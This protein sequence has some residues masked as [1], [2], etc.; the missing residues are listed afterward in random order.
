MKTVTEEPDF[1]RDAEL[2]N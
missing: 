2:I 1:K